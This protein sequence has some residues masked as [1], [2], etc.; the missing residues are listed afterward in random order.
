MH[1]LE[2]LTRFV[3]ITFPIEVHDGIKPRTDI[4]RKSFD[5]K[6]SINKASMAIHLLIEEIEYFSID[7][8]IDNVDI[9]SISF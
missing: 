1:Q 5:V 7:Q 4:S 3:A 8:D 2:E 6:N 9:V